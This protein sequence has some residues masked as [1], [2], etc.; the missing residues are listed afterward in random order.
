MLPT[1]HLDRFARSLRCVVMSR[2]LPGGAVVHSLLPICRRFYMDAAE[3]LHEV[4]F[5]SNIGMDALVANLRRFPKVSTIVLDAPAEGVAALS[6]L[7][8]CASL[9]SLHLSGCSRVSDLSA[10][11]SCTSL[12]ALGLGGCSGVS[13]LAALASCTSLRT[14]HLDGCWRVS[15]LSALAS[16]T[17]IFR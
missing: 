15:D 11:A 13:D 1:D 17:H 10:L 9:R 14:L 7:A 5:C 4:S 6:A 12:R 8:S 16:C 2:A 3:C